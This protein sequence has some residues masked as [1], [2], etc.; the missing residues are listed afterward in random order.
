MTRQYSLSYLTLERDPAETIEHAATAGYDYVGVRILPAVEQGKAFPLFR[1]KALLAETM[2]RARDTG[3]GVLDVEIA[4]IDGRSGAEDWLPMLEAAGRLG[5]RTVIAAGDDPDLSRMTDTFA[6]LCAAAAPF[7]LTV[8]LEFTPWTALRDARMALD[9]VTAS[10][11]ANAEVLIDTIHVARSTT[12]LDDLRAI[13][14][15]R[16]SYIQICDAPAGVPTSRDELLFTARQ[17]RLLPGEGGVD[18]EAQVA[19]LPASLI[20][21]VEIPS[22]TRIASVGAAQWARR[23]L[24]VSRAAMERFDAARQ[25]PVPARV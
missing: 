6:A 10:G 21:S 8:N 18:I 1:D 4:R 2:R 16:M 7:G 11:A 13:P 15:S 23:T 5:A 17:E 3:I 9:V 22:H 12:T 19:A 14:P 25:S 20:V 24:D